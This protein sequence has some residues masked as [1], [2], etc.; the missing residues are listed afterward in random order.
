MG[1]GLRD[2]SDHDQILVRGVGVGTKSGK[3]VKMQID[4][5]DKQDKETGFSSMERMTGFSTS[6]NAIHVAEGKCPTGAVRYENCVPGKKF[7]EELQ[8][9]G[10]KLKFAEEELPASNGKKVS[11]K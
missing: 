8:K 6:I 9:R 10:I 7:V 2:P 4:I 11:A 5:H 1:E 3:R